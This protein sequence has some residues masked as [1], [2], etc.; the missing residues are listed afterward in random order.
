M[1]EMEQGHLFRDRPGSTWVV[2]RPR[3][4]FHRE[5]GKEKPSGV[6]KGLLNMPNTI[7]LSFWSSSGLH[8]S[9]ESNTRL[10]RF[11]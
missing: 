7:K 10:L 8:L 3:T 4:G 1:A 5:P 11:A 2:Q 9:V 6:L